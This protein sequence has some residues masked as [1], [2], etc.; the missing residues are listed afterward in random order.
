MGGKLR[1][2]MSMGRARLHATKADRQR[3]YRDRRRAALARPK[4]PTQAA[5]AASADI[6]VRTM[7][8]AARFERLIATAKSPELEL[9][10]R[11]LYARVEAGTIGLHPALDRAETMIAM[12]ALTLTRGPVDHLTASGR[13]LKVVS[14][15]DTSRMRKP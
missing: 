14:E 12:A 10:L 4:I 5:M 8:R 15:S 1:Y 3:A 9:K 13:P 2:A 6:S 11:R 7:Q